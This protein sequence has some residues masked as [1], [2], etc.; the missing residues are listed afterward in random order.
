[1][2]V[3]T[4]SPP[5]FVIAGGAAAGGSGGS[6]SCK[7]RFSRG[8]YCGKRVLLLPN[9]E[10]AP[11]DVCS[12]AH[13]PYLN[14]RSLQIVAGAAADEVWK[15]AE[16]GRAAVAT[17]LHVTVKDRAAAISRIEA[18]AAAEERSVPARVAQIY[19]ASIAAADSHSQRPGPDVTSASAAAGHLPAPPAQ[20]SGVGTARRPVQLAV[21]DDAFVGVEAGP[22]PVLG[23]AAEAAAGVTSAG[24]AQQI[25]AQARQAH[26]DAEATALPAS[27]HPIRQRAAAAQV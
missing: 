8:R 11:H 25:A 22:L 15:R 16:A 7:R 5:T 19:A 13:C 1:M 26:L 4:H 21:G 24:R 18:A 27:E 10:C 3:D 6:G 12:A 14:G 9:L 2:N 23:R 20:L 17:D